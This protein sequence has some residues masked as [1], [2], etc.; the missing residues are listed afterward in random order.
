MN[1]SKATATF[2]GATDTGRVRKNN[3]DN[4]IA[5]EIRGGSHLLLAAIDGIGGYEGGEVAAR[6][7][8]DT[9]IAYVNDSADGNCLDILKSAVTAANNEIVA[10]KQHDPQRS[11]MG[12]V[13]SSAIISLE[14]SRLYMV[15]IGDSR[16]YRFT[17]DSG[18]TKLSHDHSLVGFRE[19]IGMLTE[20]QAMKHPQRN[21]IER[22]LGDIFHSPDDENF[23]DAGIFPIFGPTQFLFCSDGLSDMIYSAEIAGVLASD[24]SARDEVTRLIDMANEAGGKDNITAV[25]AKLSLPM[26]APGSTV[27]GREASFSGISDLPPADNSDDLIAADPVDPTPAASGHS[28]KK[29][30]GLTRFRIYLITTV[31]AFLAGGT[32][33]Y[34]IGTYTGEQRA[35]K[36]IA[37]DVTGKTLQDSVIIP[38]NNPDST[39]ADSQRVGKQTAD[40]INRVHRQ[41]ADSARAKN[42]PN[43]SNNP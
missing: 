19:E 2:F 41:A 9:I 35:Q 24:K 3:E 26:P 28:N 36:A 17:P 38:P 11:N 37:A 5:C 27:S 32:V 39:V 10:Q 1:Q 14:E 15:H 4:Y 6:I 21:I 33:G 8:R 23:L 13:L 18:L 43:R 34:F 20:E 16:L 30:D 12:C 22:S 25:I 42:K 31:I 29:Q 40:S 7:A